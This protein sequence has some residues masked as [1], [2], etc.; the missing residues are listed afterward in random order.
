MFRWKR[1][2]FFLVVL[3]LLAACQ[4]QPAETEA[5]N[6]EA[7]SEEPITLHFAGIKTYA[8]DSWTDL[9]A[10]FEAENPEIKVEVNQMPAPAM[11]TEIHQYLVTSLQSKQNEIDVFTGDVIWVPE[12]AAAGWVEPADQYVEKSE[13]YDGVVEAL[14][15]D[16][17]L[18]AVPWYVDGG[19]L[20]YRKDLLDKH[21][22]DVPETW[23][24]LLQTA[25]A[26]QASEGDPDLEQFVWQAKQSEVLV[27]NFVEY[28][29]S[30]GSSLLDENGQP[31]I[32]TPEMNQ[33][34]DLMKQT[35]D[36]GHSPEAILTF[37]EEPSRTVFTD[38]N[39]IFMRNWT[40]AWSS[41]QDEEQSNVVGKVGVAPLPRFDNGQSASTM[42]GYQFM[43]AKDAE[44]KEAAFKLANFLSSEQSQLQ[45]AEDL[46]FSPTRPSVLENER[47]QETNPFLTELDDVF[48]GVVPRPVSP[49][50]PKSHWP[51]SLAYLPSSPV[52]YRLKRALSRWKKK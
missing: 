49:D 10:E 29:R 21:G 26:I 27:C 41:A 36:N 19:L 3:L 47:L 14:T 33:T 28:L 37:D 16:G 44:H 52:S 22:Y 9:I 43:V 48:R 5:T 7:A 18:M 32:D 30:T 46:A 51:F 45:Y 38:G 15:Y 50:Y 24:E 31:T 35:L 2:L 1:S 42:G 23:E 8:Q 12:F 11:S 6:E 34:L 40:Y 4:S 20:Y 39:A 25:E 17:Q 13:Y